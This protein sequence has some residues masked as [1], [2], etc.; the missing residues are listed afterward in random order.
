VNHRWLGG[1]LTNWRTVSGSIS[2][3][4]ELEAV[5]GAG[6]GTRTKKELL[7]LTR[8][9]DKLELSLG[10]IKDMG[11]VPD[12]IFVIDTN[13]EALAIQE[14]NRLNIPVVA[15]V[16]HEMFVYDGKRKKAL[17]KAKWRFLARYED[18][19]EVWLSWRE[20]DPLA[21][22]DDYAQA[23]PELKIPAR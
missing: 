12:L 14:A 23:H 22:L 7:Q 2:R 15:I 16:D 13:K 1:T 20:A 5:L 19:E 11:G 10:G 21:A 18:G 4:R 9:R 3:L 17:P 8:E 6:E